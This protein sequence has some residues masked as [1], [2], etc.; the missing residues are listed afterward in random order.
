[1]SKYLDR[2][3]EWKAIIMGRDGPCGSC[4]INALNRHI[5]AICIWWREGTEKAPAC[6]TVFNCFN[7]GKETA[8]AAVH[9]YCNSPKE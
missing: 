4:G 7:L 8:Q 3:A 1:L 9:E 6:S 5:S 2:V